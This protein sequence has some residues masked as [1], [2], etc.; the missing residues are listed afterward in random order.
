[1]AIKHFFLRSKNWILN[2]LNKVKPGNKALKG[3]AYGLMTGSIALFLFEV[4]GMTINFRDPWILLL[5]AVILLLAILAA[6][7]IVW[8]IK[9]IHLI[10]KWYKIA[11]F[12]SIPLLMIVR[13]LDERLMLFL[14]VIFSLLGAGVSIF[15]FSHFKKLS[16]PKKTIA[17]LCFAVGLVGA[18]ASLYLLMIK[19]LEMKPIINAAKLSEEKINPIDL[20]SPAIPGKYEV[21][22]FTYGSGIDIR[23]E[24]FAEGVTY[25]TES[26]DGTA[27]LDH[28]E[29]ISGKYRTYYWGFDFRELPIN[30]RGWKPKGDGPFPLVLIVHG[31]HPMQD[32]SDPGYEYL[33]ELMASRGFVFVSVDENFLNGSWSDFRKGLEKENDA[34]GWM[35]LEHLRQWQ[36]W[37]EDPTHV[38]FG[39]IDL[40]NLALIGHSRGGEAVAHAAMLNQ[41]DHYPD[42]ASIPLGYHFNIQSIVAIAPVDGQY[43]PGGSLTKFENVSYLGI[44]G[45]Q[46]QDVESFDGAKQFERIS[47]TDSAY[48]F[49]A[50]IYIS[51]ANHGQFNSS[52]GDNDA[53]ASLSGMLNK[54]QLMDAADQETIAKVYISAFLETTLHQKDSYLPLFTDARK[55]RNWLPE[56]IYLSQFEDSKSQFWA[57]FDEDFDVK[58]LSKAESAKGQNLTVWREGEVMPKYGLRGTRA[59]Y[60]GWNYEKFGG[61]SLDWETPEKPILPDSIR[62]SYTITVGP[63]TFQPDSSSVLI[64]SLAESDESSNPKTKGKWVKNT[65][66]ENANE[67]E[68]DAEEADE[69]DAED[70]ENEIDQSKKPLPVLDFAIV[71]LDHQ[72]E[73][74]SFLASEFSPVQRLIKSRVLK[75]QFLDD[76][77]ETEPI[78]QLYQFDLKKFVARNPKF[79]LEDL[80]QIQFIFDQSEQGVLIL[81]QL[82]LMPSFEVGRYS[83]NQK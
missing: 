45:A 74:V 78:F 43:K 82:G 15:N 64:F 21:E 12:L 33:G 19:G 13:L 46:D 24:E 72:G 32:F 51:G 2:V 5:G 66:N 25:Q 59:V 67:T 83:S 14:I 3:S 6:F 73:R 63:D 34:R 30:G 81:D 61:D 69:K 42:D 38:L 20:E 16:L 4:L 75:I 56:T 39:Q 52:W 76:K 8:L 65:N 80:H 27:F 9:Q 1:M 49:K 77:D 55:G 29:G 79:S 36:K 26:V 54:G 50:G 68:T 23:R 70:E 44:H 35:L 60:L 18:G 41:L 48:R 71:L 57:G 22:F 17:I 11:L 53:L 58:T 7:L 37:S 31:N 10:P 47:F 40:D 28:W 62:A